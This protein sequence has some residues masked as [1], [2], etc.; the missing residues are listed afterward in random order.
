MPNSKR[1]IS[2]DEIRA[3]RE[4]LGLSQV[5]AGELIGGG[6]RAFT[7]YEAG[8]VKPAASVVNLLRVVE[9]NPSAMATLR[10]R[11]PGRLAAGATLPFEAT[12]KDIEALDERTFPQLLRKLLNAEAQANDL[13][14]CGIHVASSIYSPDGGEDARI[15]WIDGP[16]RTS[17]LPSRLCQF[18]AKAGK[19]SPTA[20]AREVVPKGREVKALVRS[21]LEKGGHYIMLCGHHYVQTSIQAR[22]SH[23]REA[24]REAG[25]SIE[26][27]QVDFR[28]TDQVAMWVN[29]HPSV[30][31]WVKERTQPGTLG[32]FRSWSHWAG[33]PEHSESPW[34]EDERFVN[35]RRHLRG[36]VAEPRNVLRVVGLSGVGKSRLTLEALASTQED[37][38]AGRFLSDMVI[39]AIQSE[40]GPE[41]INKVVQNL[42]DIGSRAIVVVDNC[43]PETHQV[44]AGMILRQ[45]SRLS[46]VTIDNEIPS[47][48]LDQTTSKI[49]QAPSTVIESIINHVSPGLQTEDKQRLVRFAKGFPKIA[50]L[51]GRSWIQNIPVARATD[52]TLVDTFILGRR[53]RDPEVLLKSAA[54]LAAFGLVGLQHPFD[55]QLSEIANMG[56]NLSADDL[57]AAIIRLVNLGV[58]QRR[59][60]Y[61][62]L[63]PRPIA[64]RL[65]ERQWEEWSEE[66]WDR[67]LSGDTS[68]NLKVL[69]VRQLALLNTVGISHRVLRHVCRASGPFQGFEAIRK[70]GHAEVLSALAEIDPQIVVRQIE[71]CLD[72]VD[73]LSTLEGDARRH[74]VHA[75]E[76]IAF[77][78][79]TFEEGALL[80]LRLAVAENEHW[81]NNS[82][83]QFQALFPMFLG[84]T[85]A[86]G[87]A[88]LSVLDEA[89]ETK[90]PLQR[91]VVV[92]A[93]VAG[94]E[95]HYFGRFAGGEVHGS[96][97]ALKS[98]HPAARDEESNYIEGCVER[99]SQF[100]MG[101]DAPGV[102]ARS[103]LG[104]QLGTL[105]LAGYIN[106]VE[107][108][109]HQVGAVRDDWSEGLSSLRAVL[110]ND[111]QFIDPQ[112]ATRVQQLAKE[113]QPK[114]VKSRVYSVVTEASWDDSDSQ[115]VAAGYEIR[116]E[117]VRELAAE[118]L[119]HRESLA[120][121]LPQ[122]SRGQQAHAEIFGQ[123]IAES[124]YS[125]L[126]WLEPIVEAVVDAP[127]EIRNYSLLS[128]FI[129]GLAKNNP[130]A[131]DAFKKRAARMRELTPA[132][133]QICWRLGI[134]ASDIQLVVRALKSG[135]LSP[136]RLN[137]WAVGGILAEVSAPALGSLFDT[138]IE[139]SDEAFGQA[140]DLMG[141]FVHGEPQKLDS[142]RPQVVKVAE[143]ATRWKRMPGQ[144]PRGQRMDDFHF[145]QI[146]D[147]M[148]SKGRHDPDARA[149]AL[150]LTKAF[151]SVEGFQDQRLVIRVIRILLTNFPE[152]TWALIGHA[153]VTDKRRA[154]MFEVMLGNP[155]DFGG[156]PNSVIL[157]LPQDTLF[158]WCQAHPDRAPAFAARVL[159][160]LT[161]QRVD[162][163]D[164]SLHP[165]MSRLLDE[166]GD[167]KDV[168]EAIEH[169]MH[170]FGWL[171]SIS[172][173]FDLYKEP[174][175][176][177]LKHPKPK[178]RRWAK[179]MLRQLDVAIKETR[180][181]DEEEEA[182]D[183][184]R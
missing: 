150:A 81:G 92:E 30:A 121:L 161:T 36:R 100:A 3:I 82:T 34:V 141:M 91:L 166:F 133:P 136:W 109:V 137:Q 22:K 54:L 12:G 116:A 177:L 146:M 31:T 122:L 165:V 94:S 169:N 128:G 167:R 155:Y 19:I 175:G 49:E 37:E 123:A 79:R 27:D 74:V 26:G 176:G 11:K 106:S 13:P 21:V 62:I 76:K 41:S 45:S 110:A 29:V 131:V 104:A 90:D 66:K 46:L 51:I 7:K 114:S 89:M 77:D 129:A 59:G 55:G 5:E 151:V 180:Q 162:V 184:A 159:P 42:A 57:R 80:L 24:L 164:R 18:Q 178:L 112:V 158:A 52:D 119:S 111:S 14:S 86:G 68:V 135:L 170:H 38:M 142:L 25:M 130:V 124:A 28:D 145:E 152:L 120:A 97:P 1:E 101:N 39:Y 115:D 73:N 69:A 20:A 134:T 83:G 53:P 33:R 16:S 93:L 70:A 56:R 48:T 2:P 67:L 6:P 99:L 102:K 64:M 163:P 125:P 15:E 61:V 32:P 78:P 118:L 50:V 105:V 23:I 60:R 71:R 84:S 126:E 75:L 179:A 149:A 113:L 10:G 182:L 171:G 144:Q 108:V 72:A 44:L 88:R 173:Y 148:L 172:T 143:Y 47:G 154:F 181:A 168:Q 160:I 85:A 138:M 63:Q 132:L 8:T 147:W 65:A 17:F 183:E 95:T 103:G 139:H 98:W 40:V 35:F 153:I 96:R 174:L 107:E 140:V 117:K 43:D 58:A 157:N 156:E 127:D 4:R 9:A 87:D